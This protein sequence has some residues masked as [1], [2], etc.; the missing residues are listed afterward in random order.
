MSTRNFVLAAEDEKYLTPSELRKHADYQGDA[1]PRLALRA[2]ARKLLADTNP[3]MQ[4]DNVA[5]FLNS[6]VQG[7]PLS[8]RAQTSIAVAGYRIVREIYEA[9][10]RPL[11]R[12]RNFGERTRLELVDLFA[13]H[14]LIWQEDMCEAPKAVNEERAVPCPASLYSDLLRAAKA[15][16]D[17]YVKQYGRF[18]SRGDRYIEYLRLQHVVERAESL[19]ALLHE[20]TDNGRK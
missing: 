20:E 5:L 16:F 7:L 6:P 1:E 17:A 19:V 10:W 14:G 13:K 11:M 15:N 9:G 4:P 18:A 3:S 8:V 2:M 12:Q